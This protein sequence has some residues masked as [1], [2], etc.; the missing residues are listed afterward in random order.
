MTQRRSILGQPWFWF[1]LAI[2]VSATIPVAIRLVGTLRWRHELATAHAAGAP[3]SFADV[4]SRAPVVDTAR[5]ERLY[6]WMQSV[7]SRHPAWAF[8]QLWAAMP[9]ADPEPSTVTF[10]TACMDTT[11]PADVGER[12]R[13]MASLG[14]LLDSGPLVVGS[15]GWVRQDFSNPTIADDQQI[16]C[17]RQMSPWCLLGAGRELAAAAERGDSKALGRLDAF[18]HAT[19][20]TDDLFSLPWRAA[21]EDERDIAYLHAIAVGTLS[22]A[23]AAAWLSEPSRMPAIAAR[24]CMDDRIYSLQPLAEHGMQRRDDPRA[25]PLWGLVERN[26]LSAW[27][28]LML[29]GKCAVWSARMRA[30]AASFDHGATPID[31]EPWLHAPDSRL[32]YMLMTMPVPMLEIC[33]RTAVEDVNRHRMARVLGRLLLVWQAEHALPEADTCRALCHDLF[34]ATPLL[35]AL[36]L[37]RL[38]ATRFRI[39]IDPHG[40]LPAFIPRHYL[41]EPI[42]GRGLLDDIGQPPRAAFKE[43]PWSMELDCACLPAHADRPASTA[44]AHTP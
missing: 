23:T 15:L 39:G 33:V 42:Y 40:P 14:A 30:L 27:W 12:D 35:P 6:A 16:A 8:F 31:T 9:L 22:P 11:T 4:V 5:Q 21:I 18:L 43:L 44:N 20:D 41:T 13:D 36:H 3:A 19:D 2:A 28:W 7:E 37:E 1:T 38:S 17:R 25:G 32:A 29:P 24:T 26:T 10:T 34:A